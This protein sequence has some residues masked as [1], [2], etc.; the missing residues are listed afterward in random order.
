ME[1]LE[2]AERSVPGDLSPGM[3]A[4]LLVGKVA[5]ILALKMTSD[6]PT[7]PTQLS[8]LCI[9]LARVID[10]A[11]A[12]NEV[13]PRAQELPFLLRQVYKQCDAFSIQA[14]V[15]VLMISVKNAC[16]MGWF[17]DKD[18]VNLLTLAK[19]GLFVAQIDNIS[20]S[21]CIETPPQANFL[22]NG[23]GVLGRI[24]ISMDTGP[25]LPTNITTML[26][27]GMNFLQAVGQFDSD[28]IIVI[29][30]IHQKSSS[31]TPE[32]QNYVQPVAP[33]D[34]SSDVVAEPSQV[35]LNCP[36]SKRRIRTPVKGHCCKHYQCFDYESFMILN[37]TRP[38]WC[39]PVCNQSVCCIDIRMD[40]N[41]AKILRE[42]RENVVDVIVSADGSWKV[43]GSDDNIDQ[44]Y[45]R[46]QGCQGER[47]EVHGSS[48]FSSVPANVTDLKMK[49]ADASHS[50]GTLESE[51]KE[52]FQDNLFHF[53]VSEN[54]VSSEANNPGGAL[55]NAPVQI[56]ESSK[57]LSSMLSTPCSS[58]VPSPSMVGSTTAGISDFPHFTPTLPSAHTNFVSPVLNQESVFVIEGNQVPP[59]LSH[60]R[61]LD[62]NNVHLHQFRADSSIA[63][64]EY[65]KNANR[66][67]VTTMNFPN[68]AQCSRPSEQMRNLISWMPNRASFASYQNMPLVP[69]DVGITC[70]GSTERGQQFGRVPVSSLPVS[71]VAS[72][73]T[74]NNLLTQNWEGSG[75]CRVSDQVVQQVLNGPT[76]VPFASSSS[77]SHRLPPCYQ[78]TQH[79]SSS[80]MG[81]NATCPSQNMFQ[82]PQY[83]Y[84]SST[85]TTQA[86]IPSQNT[87]HPSVEAQI[88]FHQRVSA[89]QVAGTVNNNR[90]PQRTPSQPMSQM[91]RTPPF[92]AVQLQASGARYSLTHN[93]GAQHNRTTVERRSA[94]G[95]VQPVPVAETSGAFAST[96]NWR[97]TGRMRGSL[98]GQA[99]AAA[100]EQF[101]TRPTQPAQSSQNP[102]KLTTIPPTAQ[103]MRGLATKRSNVRIN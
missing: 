99:Y 55:Q 82:A 64:N 57:I 102:S 97:P 92:V 50:M 19:E 38:S 56:G 83:S 47:P 52:R 23:E 86:T 4:S 76:E 44:A 6:Q 33:S 46:T 29:A 96:E 85:R 16:K 62:N 8:D 22:L 17:P 40:Q 71:D 100:L 7:D 59:S 32:L 53:P 63:N 15:M 34:S 20:T 95:T 49:Q 48:G 3:A 42:V 65:G 89:N 73:L 28:Y 90:P 37:S 10:Y 77:Q 91:T 21:S 13:P 80:S 51:G 11:V 72:S 25:Q 87:V 103:Q 74:L 61:V 9:Y 78:F 26:N 45:G 31:D 43:V 39:C 67:S 94:V 79:C 58:A 81:A 84:L 24:N 75:S 66:V 101:M 98:K 35:S 14:A 88:Q 2:R 60:D 68:Q 18:I 12:Y 93:T 70:N 5:D 41:I 1:G 69:L 30:Y 27:H 54:L 36:I